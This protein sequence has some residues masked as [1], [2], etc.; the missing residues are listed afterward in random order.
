M[1][2]PLIYQV[3]DFGNTTSTTPYSSVPV[4]FL[5]HVYSQPNC[6]QK[7]YLYG[8]SPEGSCTA[9]QVG[10]PF[11]LVLIADNYC[12]NS[13]VTMKDIAT[14][15]FPIVIKS[16]IVQNSTSLWSVTLKWT[17]T[18]DQVGSQ[19]FCSVGIDRL[20]K[21]YKK[22]S[23]NICSVVI[24]QNVQTNQYCLTF[25]VGNGTLGTCPGV[26]ITTTEE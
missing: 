14:Q 9:V 6:T 4:Q 7:P 12:Y 8:P 3:E 17:P 19:V 13:S 5:V 10:V 11:T 16:P 25:S 24:S 26:I 18:A 15:S 22:N 21:I 1:I 20:V 2:V 23:F